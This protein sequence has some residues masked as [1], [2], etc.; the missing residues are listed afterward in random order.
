[1]ILKLVT[2]SRAITAKILL[3]R[4]NYILIDKLPL[5]KLPFKVRMSYL[6][7]EE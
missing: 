5:E 4:G 3:S 6:G 1:M 7:A 2:R